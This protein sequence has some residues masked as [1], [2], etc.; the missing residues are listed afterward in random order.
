MQELLPTITSASAAADIVAAYL[1]ARSLA[2]EL[3]EPATPSTRWE[4]ALTR[5]ESAARETES[6]SQLGTS[7]SRLGKARAG[8]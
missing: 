2:H 4:A 1:E 3:D 5:A 8:E 7:P 6:E